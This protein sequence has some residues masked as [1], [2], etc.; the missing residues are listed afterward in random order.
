MP[1]ISV[2]VPVY[3][4]EPYLRRCVDSIL[5]Q[6][7]TDFEL[8]L[9]DDG[10]PDNCPNICDEY[11]EKDSRIVVIH[12]KNGGISSAR[13]AAI[14]WITEHSKSEW[15]TFVDSDDVVHHQMLELLYKAVC[16]NQADMSICPVIESLQIPNDWNK[17]VVPEM[18]LHRVDESY[19]MELYLNGKQKYWTAWAKLVRKEYVAKMP[20]EEGRIFED[21]NLVFKWL[22]EAKQIADVHFP[23]YFYFV[24]AQGVSKSSFSIKHLDFLHALD[25]QVRFYREKGYSQM[26][27]KLC[28]SYLMNSANMYHRVRK[29]LANELVAKKIKRKMRKFCMTHHINVRLSKEQAYTLLEVLH[30]HVVGLYWRLK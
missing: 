25:T 5:M 18:T 26:Y 9:V 17:T 6:T 4:V 29:D 24:N 20:F 28:A 21:N 30:P 10:S 1:V 8:I 19:I 12:Q 7:F 16:D 13:N 2:I 11:A 15:V 23:L 22:C 27:K 14:C 3:N